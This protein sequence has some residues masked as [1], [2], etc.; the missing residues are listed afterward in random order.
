MQD[1][2]ATVR[3][4]LMA[5]LAA[6]QA[7][8][9][10]FK[11]TMLELEYMRRATDWELP[12]IDVVQ[13]ETARHE[14]RYVTTLEGHGNPFGRAIDFMEAGTAYILTRDPYFLTLWSVP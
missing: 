12:I 11:P 7:D 9:V 5:T 6:C 8:G 2:S 3:D 10:P 13:R 4:N 1:L 14:W